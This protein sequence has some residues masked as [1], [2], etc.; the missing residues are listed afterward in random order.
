M[1]TRLQDLHVWLNEELGNKHGILNT[2]IQHKKQVKLTKNNGG[3]NNVSFTLF[4]KSDIKRGRMPDAAIDRVTFVYHSNP[5]IGINIRSM[6]IMWLLPYQT[7]YGSFGH[8][9]T[10]N[11]SNYFDPDSV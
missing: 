6:G 4:F 9:L 10:L 5:Y 11:G 3:P 8:S 1:P 2:L 7:C